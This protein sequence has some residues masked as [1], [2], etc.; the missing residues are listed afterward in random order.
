MAVLDHIP[1]RGITKAEHEAWVRA[2]GRS[3]TDRFVAHHQEP[4]EVA[5]LEDKPSKVLGAQHG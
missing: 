1:S 4:G 3:Y 2:S 5:D